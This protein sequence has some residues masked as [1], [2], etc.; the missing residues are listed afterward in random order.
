MVLEESNGLV[1]IALNAPEQ[2][3]KSLGS[4]P[5]SAFDADP[6][7]FVSTDSGAGEWWSALF[8]GVRYSVTKV[9]I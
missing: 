5:G 6:N 9:R 4:I 7:T 2:S 3:S 1:E 8:G